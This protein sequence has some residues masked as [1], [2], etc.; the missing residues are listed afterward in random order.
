M[1]ILASGLQAQMFC[2][3]VAAQNIANADTTRG[4]GGGPYRRRVAL[5][6][7]VPGAE[8]AGVAAT[9]VSD[10]SPGPR[11]FDPE[12][13]DADE[14]GRVEYPNVD[15]ATETVNLMLASRAYSLNL[16]TMRVAQRTA[17][18]L[19]DMVDRG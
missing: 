17:Q 1:G 14:R 10:P 9:L 18:D 7:E 12:H 4:A 16:A 11:V 6:G 15:F 3:D 19:L 13:P 2:A 5:L 8:P